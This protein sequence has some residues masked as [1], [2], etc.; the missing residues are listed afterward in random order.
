MP[1][2]GTSAA[3]RAVP[4]AA[5]V[6]PTDAIWRNCRRALVIN[7]TSSSSIVPEP[8]A[9]KCGSLSA[10]VDPAAAA[11]AEGN[12]NRAGD[13]T[14]ERG[15]RA[16]LS[17]Q[18]AVLDAVTKLFVLLAGRAHDRKIY[19]SALA[20]Q[21]QIDHC[22]SVGEIDRPS[23]LQQRLR[24]Q[25]SRDIARQRAQLKCRLERRH[26]RTEEKYG[27]AQSARGRQRQWTHQMMQ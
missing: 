16:K 22:V 14:A 13:A 15:G 19:Y 9:W 20:V 7:I 8:V 17:E 23:E 11:A 18:K 5:L 24:A 3:C 6:T 27:R 2:V 12:A 4:S 26:Q 10:N 25:H 21:L 1:S